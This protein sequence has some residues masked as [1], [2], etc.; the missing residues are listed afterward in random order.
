MCLHRCRRVFRTRETATEICQ[1]VEASQSEFLSSA[2]PELSMLTTEITRS[3]VNISSG[4]NSRGQ[5]APLT[6]IDTKKAN[7]DGNNTEEEVKT[8]KQMSRSL[9]DLIYFVYNVN[10]RLRLIEN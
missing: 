10:Y 9:E 3:L 7:M 8:P 6:N 5:R 2:I 4:F 1:S